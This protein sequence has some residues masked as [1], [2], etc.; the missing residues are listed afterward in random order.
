MRDFDVS[1]AS[2]FGKAAIQCVREEES[3]Y[4]ATTLDYASQSLACETE[5]T[6]ATLDAFVPA[7][8]AIRDTS[9][10][11]LNLTEQFDGCGHD[12]SAIPCIDEVTSSSIQFYRNPHCSKP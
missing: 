1:D 4:K 12:S 8:T 5:K 6:V 10:A 2:D 7:L 11:V 9:S 3:D